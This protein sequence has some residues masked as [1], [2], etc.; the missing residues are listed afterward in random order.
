MKI[1]IIILSV[2]ALIV[3]MPAIAQDVQKDEK[4]FYVLNKYG[5]K[6]R[7]ASEKDIEARSKGKPYGLI[8]K[9]EDMS[10]AEKDAMAEDQ[11]RAEAFRKEQEVNQIIAEKQRQLAIEALEQEG[12][13][14]KENGKLKKVEK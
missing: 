11:A 5:S 4:G 2:M 12:V 6:M 13:I 1:K 8:L 10:Q 3:T 14:K 7:F 9:A